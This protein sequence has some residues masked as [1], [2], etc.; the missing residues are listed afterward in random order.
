MRPLIIS[1][2]IDTIGSKPVN[3]A[4]LSVVDVTAF[5]SLLGISA[6]LAIFDVFFEA[7]ETDWYL[8]CGQKAFS[9]P[10]IEVFK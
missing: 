8:R 1:L 5:L 10:N 3:L 6:F 2:L 4:L 9:D 7:K